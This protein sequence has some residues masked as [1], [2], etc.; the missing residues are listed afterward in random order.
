[1]AKSGKAGI[2]EDEI[3]TK[4]EDDIDAGDD[5]DVE[6]I[7]HSPLSFHPLLERI[8]HCNAGNPFEV[9]L[10]FRDNYG[11]LVLYH[12]SRDQRIPEGRTMKF[13]QLNGF[14]NS[15]RAPINNPP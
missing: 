2:A 15:L 6:E 5:Q 11:N 13:H 12:A 8:D 9:A 7:L 4:G 1:M 14:E 3:Q 10:V